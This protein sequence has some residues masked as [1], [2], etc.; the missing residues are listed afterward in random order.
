MPAT[1]YRPNRRATHEDLA[2]R[3]E[4]SHEGN[5]NSKRE[6][7]KDQ[8][9]SEAPEM[10]VSSVFYN[11]EGEMYISNSYQNEGEKVSFEIVMGI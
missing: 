3:T 10:Q 1:W 2:E 7:Q 6:S 9:W 8:K 5:A 4:L 11:N